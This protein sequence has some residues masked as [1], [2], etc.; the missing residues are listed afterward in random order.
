MSLPQPPSLPD[1]DALLAGFH[2]AR[3]TASIRAEGGSRMLGD[4]TVS[5]L[6]R[7]TALHLSGVK[8]RDHLP[9]AETVMSVSV[10]HGDYAYS[11][12]TRMMPPLVSSEGDTLFP[13][14]VR[15]AWPL[16]APQVR[17]RRALRVAAPDHPAL[18]AR[19]FVAGEWIEAQLINLTETGLGLGLA[20]PMNLALQMVVQVETRLPGGRPLATTGEVRHLEI[21]EDD[22]LPTRMGMVLGPLDEVSREHLR[23]FIQ[24]RRTDRSDAMR[25]SS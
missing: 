17:P 23:A 3:A 6:E 5:G 11:F 25:Q 10:L 12:R 4:L 1:L 24:D 16:E 8:R 22:P 18:G 7:G 14:I 13:P 19:L 20:A 15:L 21:L 9:P 2:K